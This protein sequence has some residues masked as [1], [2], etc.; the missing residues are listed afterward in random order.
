MNQIAQLVCVQI[1]CRA[2][3]FPVYVMDGGYK[4]RIMIERRGLTMIKWPFGRAER[5]WEHSGQLTIT[6]NC[7][8]LVRKKP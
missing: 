2:I 4:V 5:A 1:W 6:Q 8:N 3:N 7:L